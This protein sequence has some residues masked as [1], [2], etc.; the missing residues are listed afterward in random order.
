LVIAVKRIS[1]YRPRIGSTAISFLGSLYGPFS[2]AHYIQSNCRMT[3]ELEITSK[4]VVVA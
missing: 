2:M 3:D 1:A 4:E